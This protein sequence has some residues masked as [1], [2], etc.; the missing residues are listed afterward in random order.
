MKFADF[1]AGI[2][3]AHEA[4]KALGLEC[5]FYS[6]IDS[7][8]EKTYRLIHGNS[9]K[10]YGNLMEINL[11][12]LEDFDFLVAGFPCQ[13]FSIVG[14]REGFDDERGQIIYGIANILKVKKPKVFLLENVKGLINLKGGEVL[15]QILSLLS[16]AGY[17]VFFKV[18]ESS[19]FKV[20]Q[21]RE[22]VYFVGI[23]KDLYKGNFAFPNPTGKG[24]LREFLIEESYDFIL[25]QSQ[26]QSLAKYLNN[27]Y[28]QNKY[29]LNEF[30]KEDFLVLDT[31]QSDLRLYRGV[32]P[33]I[34]AGRQGILYVKNSQIRKLS[35]LEALLLQG[36]NKD[37]ASLVQSSIIQSKILF[38]AGN[39]MTITVMT[40][41]ARS[42]IKYLYE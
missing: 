39:A 5:A 10:N 31:R 13:A 21:G 11:E 28:N 27:K 4:L 16:G 26:I 7:V 20:P 6:E 35:G 29:N 30:L 23:R 24:D 32:V 14:K 9:Y 18:F 37:I 40:E 8:A 15:E 25:N 33:T 22:R 3:T 12:T 19:S 42:I 34:R 2:G 1:C 17:E 38:Q 41:V 36:F